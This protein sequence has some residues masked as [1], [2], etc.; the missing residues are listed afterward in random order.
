MK[1]ISFYKLV[2][3]FFILVCVF[4]LMGCNHSTSDKSSLSSS[5]NSIENSTS[6]LMYIKSNNI[7]NG[8]MV[9]AND[10]WIYY[11]NHDDGR[12][13]YRIR[14]D[15]SNEEIISS[16]SVSN[17]NIEG[18]WAYY[19]NETD[20]YKL[21]KISLDGTKKQKL[22][23]E[24][25]Y[26][27][28]I[29]NQ[30]I[31]YRSG[32]NI[33]RIKTDG[34]EINCL[35]GVS[36]SGYFFITHDWIYYLHNG[37]NFFYRARLDG[38]EVT[39]VT[40]ELICDFQVVDQ[41][42]YY[43]KWSNSPSEI[44][45]IFKMKLDGT[46]KTKVNSDESHNI[47]IDDTGWI[48]YSNYSDGFNLYKIKCDGTKRT[49]INDE[50]TSNINISGEWIYYE[51]N[52]H[53]GNEQFRIKKDGSQKEKISK[54]YKLNSNVIN[55]EENYDVSVSD[56]VM[57]NT[58]SNIH[59]E[60]IAAIQK[61]WIY[62]NNSSDKNS[63]YRIKEDGTLKQKISDD[64]P[65]YINVIGER[66]YYNFKGNIYSIRTNGQ[67]KKLL[68]NGR[69]SELLVAGD[70]IYY[71]LGRDS[72]NEIYK[73]KIDG[74]NK[75]RVMKDES[76]ED[77]VSIDYFSI[78]GDWIYYIDFYKD[79]YRVRVDGTELARISD[80]RTCA[81]VFDNN[82]L[83]YNN[84]FDKWSLYKVGMSSNNKIK[85]TEE[86]P[87]SMNQSS[88]WIYFV[89]STYNEGNLYRIKKDGSKKEVISHDVGCVYNSINIVGEWIYYIQS[90]NQEYEPLIYRMKIDGSEK[91]QVN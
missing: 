62:Y 50:Y 37:D 33:Y 83:Y 74:T 22:T 63:L 3:S 18:N 82:S 69:V 71:L 43:N 29:L 47:N 44:Q 64:K 52:G 45:R 88:D 16:D 26:S 9:D 36:T 81:F 89:G 42:I 53:Y 79:F 59:N 73:M 12:K 80:I 76:D 41:W 5:S 77:N 27:A 39:K 67:D 61:G 91:Q 48:Y 21:F 6:N 90:L 65:T 75:E 19:C 1:K 13:L 10:E 31:F 66:V 20:G 72:Y 15:G 78:I 54:K 70:T 49:K 57:G 55:L 58:N 86:K 17:I 46:C 7:N 38:N 14:T 8:G 24:S 51:S 85:L 4:S 25:A 28:Y 30:W 2:L 40:D 11:S 23:E 32:S 34:T 87:I 68:E 84:W 56:T 60:G 35:S